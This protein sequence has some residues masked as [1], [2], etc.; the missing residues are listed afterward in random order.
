MFFL[1]I[2]A[3]SSIQTAFLKIWQRSGVLIAVWIRSGK[4]GGLDPAGI[5]LTVSTDPR[6]VIDPDAVSEDLTACRC[7]WSGAA[8]LIA[9]WI[10][11]RGRCAVLIAFRIILKIS[12]DPAAS[13]ILTACR[14]SDGVPVF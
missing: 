10:I 3:V 7:S 4:S 13:S 11:R 2:R 5:I 6:C 12:T 8:G 14:G 9:F 1:T